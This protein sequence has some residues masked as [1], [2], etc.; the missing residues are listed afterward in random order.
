[1]GEE[2]SDSP[3]PLAGEENS[4]SPLPLAGEGLGERVNDQQPHHLA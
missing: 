4:D 1:L 2:N 3:L